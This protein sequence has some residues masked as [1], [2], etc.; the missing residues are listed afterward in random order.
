MMYSKHY[1]PNAN[2]VLQLTTVLTMSILETIS[3]HNPM[4]KII[5][6]YIII[7]NRGFKTG[8]SLGRKLTN[9]EQ[10]L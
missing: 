2:K 6:T 1:V 7:F 10:E 9:T 8:R 4:I 5:T 3:R